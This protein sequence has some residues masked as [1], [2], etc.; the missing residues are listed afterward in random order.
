MLFYS[1]LYYPPYQ[2]QFFKIKDKH[3]QVPRIVT[4]TV[5][6]MIRRPDLDWL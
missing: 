2:E 5:K 1:I 3:M 6:R 4:A